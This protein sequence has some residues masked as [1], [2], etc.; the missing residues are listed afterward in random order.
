MSGFLRI[1]EDAKDC[2]HATS[3]P[4]PVFPSPVIPSPL[5]PSPV[6]PSPVIPSPLILSPF[7]IKVS[8]KKKKEQTKVYDHAEPVHAWSKI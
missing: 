8:K 2:N 5:I 4:S 1:P 6:I 3:F 7:L